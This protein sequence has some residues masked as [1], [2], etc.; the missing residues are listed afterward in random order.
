MTEANETEMISRRRAFSFL[1]LAVL[2]LAISPAVLTLSEAEAQQPSAQ[3][4]QTGATTAPQS[5]RQRREERREGRRERREERREDRRE[6]REE[7][8]SHRR[9]RREERRAHRR[10]RREDRRSRRTERRQ[11][12]RGTTPSTTP[13]TPQ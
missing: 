11:Q 2:G 12:R 4:P 5:G 10:E 13:S 1:G 8:R 3:P 9:E 7:R 6:R